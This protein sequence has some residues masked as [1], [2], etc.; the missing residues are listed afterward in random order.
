MIAA[1]HSFWHWAA[2]KH[3]LSLSKTGFLRTL[4]H[5]VQIWHNKNLWGFLETK[6]SPTIL[7]A[8]LFLSICQF[9]PSWLSFFWYQNFWT[10]VPCHAE[11]R[12]QSPN[13]AKTSLAVHQSPRYP[14]FHKFLTKRKYF[15]WLHARQRHDHVKTFII[16]KMPRQKSDHDWIW[17][18]FCCW[19]IFYSW[20]LPL[21]SSWNTFL[22]LINW[23]RNKWL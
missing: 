20:L 12:R 4:H 1:V 9:I 19:W 18:I 13:D 5:C 8:S 10:S 21:Q 11:W 16:Q 2:C 15:N 22:F 14:S 17:R 23:Q 3:V 7:F 6:C